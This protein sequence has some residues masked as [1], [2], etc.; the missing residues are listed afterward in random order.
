[1]YI[2]NYVLVY[3]DA[4]SG[5]RLRLASGERITE[6]EI[7]ARWNIFATPVFLY[8]DMNGNILFRAPGYKTVEDFVDMDRFIREGHYKTRTINQF[9]NA[10]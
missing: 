10:K 7:G 1:L 3:V 9:L 6:A 5:S 4:E 2:K 8:A